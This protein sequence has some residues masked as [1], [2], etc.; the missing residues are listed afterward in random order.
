MPR[1]VC[2]NSDESKFICLWPDCLVSAEPPRRDLWYQRV[3]QPNL[4]RKRR[5]EPSFE[6]GR[7]AIAGHCGVPTSSNRRQR[8]A[9]P[10]RCCKHSRVRLRKDFT[11]LSEVLDVLQAPLALGPVWLGTDMRAHRN[12]RRMAAIGGC[13][14]LLIQKFGSN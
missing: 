11:T 14:K 3:A 5:C 7:S 4:A 2:R 10:C 6:A 12:P 1:L 9:L 8:R 13:A